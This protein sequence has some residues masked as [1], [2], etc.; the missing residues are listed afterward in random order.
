MLLCNQRLI[1]NRILGEKLLFEMFF[2][3]FPKIKGFMASFR[4][5]FFSYAVVTRDKSQKQNI[6]NLRPGIGRVEGPAVRD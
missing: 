3:A 1:I 4:L 6:V 2:K 5:S